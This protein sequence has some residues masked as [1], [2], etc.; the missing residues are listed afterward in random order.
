MDQ[1]GGRIARMSGRLGAGLKKISSGMTFFNKKVFPAI[2]FGFIAL[3]VVMT[4]AGGAAKDDLMFLVGP[5]IM[6]VFGLIV[7]KNLVWDLVDEVYDCGDVLLIRNRGEEERVAL[8]NV[9]NVSS[10]TFS[11]PPRVTLRLV[12]PGR[13]GSEVVFSPIAGFRVNPFAKNA[14]AEDLI[15][16]VDRARS[17]RVGAS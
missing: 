12:N 1:A 13:F 16:R 3:F 2:W 10:S 4:V 8:S 5:I 6:A 11:N 14:I 15:V 7:M 9:M 17:R